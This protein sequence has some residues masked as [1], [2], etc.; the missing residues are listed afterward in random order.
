MSLACEIYVIASLKGTRKFMLMNEKEK[1]RELLYGGFHD[2]FNHY[3][4][5]LRRSL[6][7]YQDGGQILA[8]LTKRCRKSAMW[9][10]SG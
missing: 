1:E 5:R 7:K 4:H 3:R 2:I 6:H 9:Q 10:H 8:P